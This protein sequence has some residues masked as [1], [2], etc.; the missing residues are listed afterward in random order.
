M[1]RISSYAEAG[2]NRMAEEMAVSRILSVIN[3]NSKSNSP[4]G[5]FFANGVEFGDHL[6]SMSTDGVGSKVLI[7][8]QLQKFNTIGI[9]CVA[10]NV[11]DL[12]ATGS[13]P[14]GFVDYIAI[15]EP[16]EEKLAQIVEGV[17]EGCN[18]AEIPLLGGETATL[19]D[20]LV[21]RGNIFDLSGTAFGVQL[22]KKVI[23]GKSIQEGDVIIGIESSG[24][25]SNGL[26]LARKLFETT[27]LKWLERL[28]TPT[29]IYVRAIKDLLCKDINIRGMA[30]ITG[31]G[32]RNLLRLGKHHFSLE[33]WEIPEIFNEIQQRGDVAPF[34]MFSTFN[35]GIGFILVVDPKDEGLVLDLLNNHFN[36]WR[37]GVVKRGDKV[38]IGDLSLFPRRE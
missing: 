30:H 15:R 13:I 37:I 16:D 6:F 19:P 32:F 12:I 33:H 3:K 28:L 31:G 10:M 1:T 29:R 27:E 21:D 20:L 11:N 24:I 35:M 17:V 34:E 18:Q 2:V 9:D 8:E 26:T 38:T 36:S 14:M 25:H 23:N 5:D 7:A 4:I 22:K